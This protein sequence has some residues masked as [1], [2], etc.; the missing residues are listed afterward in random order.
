VK[1][2]L[3]PDVGVALEEVKA[4]QGVRPAWLEGEFQPEQARQLAARFAE[5][6]RVWGDIMQGERLPED[7]LLRRDKVRIQ[8][9]TA[10]SFGGVL[11]S[12]LLGFSLG[13]IWVIQVVT[14]VILPFVEGL[15]PGVLTLADVLGIPSLSEWITIGGLPATI[16]GFLGSASVWLFRQLGSICYWLRE[17]WVPIFLEGRTVMCWDGNV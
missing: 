11:F 6:A 17:R 9:I 2:H 14:Q 1:K 4:W 13:G 15:F 7:H 8:V 3:P 5:Q 16:I 12:I 10:F